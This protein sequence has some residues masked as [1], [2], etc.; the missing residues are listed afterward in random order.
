MFDVTSLNTEIQKL[1]LVDWYDQQGI[2]RWKGGSSKKLL[3]LVRIFNKT[4]IGF[5]FSRVTVTYRVMGIRD[6]ITK[7]PSND[8]FF[9]NH[10]HEKQT[11]EGIIIRMSK[12]HTY[13]CWYTK[14]AGRWYH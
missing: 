1:L 5:L 7:Q 12:Y 10:L 6:R 14:A 13:S 4:L 11:V 3:L 8:L 2:R 9:K